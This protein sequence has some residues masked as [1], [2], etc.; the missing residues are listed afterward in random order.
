MANLLYDTGRNAFLAGT[1]SWTG[2]TIGAVLVDTDDYTINSATDQYLSDIPA[3]ARVAST[4]VSGTSATAGIADAADT[5]FSSVTGDQSEA[6]VLYQDS[7]DENTSQ[8]IVYIDD[9]T[10]LPVTPNGGDITVIWA[11]TINKI[12]KL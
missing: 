11:E 7:G 12:F 2:D 9:A 5:V 1:I 3:G 4:T 8:L 10:N 6:I